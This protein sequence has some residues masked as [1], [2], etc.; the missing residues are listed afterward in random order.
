VATPRPKRFEYAVDVGRD[1]TML[2][3][4][5]AATS[6]ADAWS[7]DHLLLAALV[8]C[9]LTSLRYHADRA[10]IGVEASGSARGVVTRRD[11]DGLYAF[12]EIEAE[13]EAS[14]S[15]QPEPEAL[16]DLLG[17]AERDCFVGASLT[18]KPTYRWDLRVGADS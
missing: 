2:A 10:G 7:P 3:D 13:M 5:E 11:S 18:V 16:R 15:P 14:L 8:R 12:V 9:V 4:G 1:G 6:V 17:K